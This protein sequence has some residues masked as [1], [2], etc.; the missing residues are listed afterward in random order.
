MRFLVRFADPVRANMMDTL[1][2]KHKG[3]GLP[4]SFQADGSR[5][6]SEGQARNSLLSFLAKSGSKETH[7]W[8]FGSCEWT[9][10]SSLKAVDI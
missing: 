10:S 5:P 3:L 1:F 6:R 7:L 9:L 2:A 8:D 4:I